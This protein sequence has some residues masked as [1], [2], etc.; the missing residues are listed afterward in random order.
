[1]TRK[2][3]KQKPWTH[4][5]EKKLIALRKEG[6]GAVTIAEVLGRKVS[7]VETRISRLKLPRA[8]KKPVLPEPVRPA[9]PKRHPMASVAFGTLKTMSDLSA[10]E[11]RFPVR[12]TNMFCGARTECGP[13]CKAHASICY[14]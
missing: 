3:E 10:D 2:N 12:D 14:V 9:A 11:C 7:A 4:T 6:A 5:E 1:M 13:Y 8:N